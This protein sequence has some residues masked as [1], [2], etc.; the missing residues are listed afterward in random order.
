MSRVVLLDPAGE[1]ETV[2]RAL[3]GHP[4]LRVERTDTLPAGHDVVAVLVPPEIPVGRDAL[5]RLPGVRIVAATATG[6]DHL[7]T[8]AIAAAGAWAT[9]CPGYCDEEVAEHAIAFVVALLRGVVLLDRS[10]RRGV[11][12]QTPSPP[13]RVA[14]ATLGIVGL[15][16]IGREV[17]RRAAALQMRVVAF[18]PLLSDAEDAELVGLNDLLE[19][20]DAITLH[21][22]LTDATREMIGAPQLARCKP[23]AYLINCARAALVDH[24]ALGESLRSGHLGGCALDVLPTE[25][26]RADEPAFGWPRTVIN[27]HSAWYSP[28]SATAPYRMAA[29]AVAAVLEGREPYAAL[30]RPGAGQTPGPRIT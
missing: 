27:P 29:E 13:R 11:W 25:P 8:D 19:R 18:D 22:L 1:L 5:A 15:G 24:T 12:D 7:D 23:G 30:A 21:A 28:G 20:S 6:F 26:P 17:A 4:E 14:G 2:A 9:H 10:A 16:R 3:T